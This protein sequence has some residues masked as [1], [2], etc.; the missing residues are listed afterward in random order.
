LHPIDRLLDEHR[1][2]LARF[3]ELRGAVR[4]LETQ[5]D[6]AVPEV[7]PVMAAVGRMMATDLL[8]HAR[9]EDEALFPAVERI[10]GRDFA[11]TG[12][13]REE[14]QDIHARAERFRATLRDLEEVE[15]PAIVTGGER[16]R[17]LVTR[18]A[19]A[20]ALRQA[21]EEVLERVDAHFAKEE[22]VLFPMAKELLPPADLAAITAAMDA[23]DR[24]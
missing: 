22:Q 18:R 9:R 13:M 16:L 19:D 2:I 8:A 15:H 7:L 24:G 10:L 20:A 6:A 21:A 3:E 14:H 5:G 12:V 11:P 23:L 1:R 17:E 4:R